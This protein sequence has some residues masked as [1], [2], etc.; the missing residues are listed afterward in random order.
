MV[1]VNLLNPFVV[2]AGEVLQSELGVKATRGALRL[3]KDTYVTDDITVLV[4]VVGDAWGVVM[5]GLSFDTANKVVSKML[6]EEVLEFNELA[7]SGISELGNVIAGHAITK[8]GAAGYKTD[9]SVPTLIVGKG[10]QISTFDIARV[11][12]PLTTDY[13][14][15][16]LTLAIREASGSGGRTGTRPLKIGG[17]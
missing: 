7:Q 17:H 13:G 3:H 14:T 2:S 10:S 16:T 4:S 6:G 15:I 8:L 1:S 11:V 5:M 9:I 12:V